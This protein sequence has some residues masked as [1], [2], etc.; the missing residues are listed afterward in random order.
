MP[1]LDHFRPPLH[2]ARRWESFHSSWANALRNQLNEG[3]LPPGYIAEVE[4]R[5]GRPIEIDVATFDESASGRASEGGVA[6]WAP[7]RPTITSIV[8]F[9]DPDVFEVQVF[10]EEGGLKLVAAIELVSPSNK[11]R[12]S[13]RR[14]FAT[15]CAAL[16]QVGV[17]VVVIDIVTTRTADLAADLR[18]LMRIESEGGPSISSSPLNVTAYRSIALPDGLRLDAWV[19][20]LALGAEL[21]VS[22]LFIEPDHALPLNLETAYL[23]A[24][25]WSRIT[26]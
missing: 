16:L 13:S 9:S 8:P 15:K 5:I 11:D 18:E 7:P 12:P 14:A 22:P 4:T 1:L 3:L 25:S 23:T 10:R 26:P 20:P 24:C 17:S 6:V 2:P 19:E 21:P